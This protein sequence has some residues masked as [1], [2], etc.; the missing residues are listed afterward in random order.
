MPR[1]TFICRDGVARTVESFRDRTLLEI[2]HLNDIDIEGTC[3]GCMGCAT[4]HVVVDPAW[5][6]RLQP[7]RFAEEEED[8]MALLSERTPTSRLGCQISLSDDLDGLVVTLGR[9]W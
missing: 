5:F 3:G 2:A 9:V 7:N 4:C 1:V 8:M 6:P